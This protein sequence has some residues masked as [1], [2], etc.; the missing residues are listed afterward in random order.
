MT[1]II[2]VKQI[3]TWSRTVLSK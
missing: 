2:T 1:N 3:V